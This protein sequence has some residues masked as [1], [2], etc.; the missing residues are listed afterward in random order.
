MDAKETRQF[1]QL[2]PRGEPPGRAVGRGEQ[3]WP[4]VAQGSSRSVCGRL[5]LQLWAPHR[6]PPRG[7]G[8]LTRWAEAPGA[9]LLE[10]LDLVLQLHLPSPGTELAQARGRAAAPARPLAVQLVHLQVLQLLPQVLDEL[11]GRGAGWREPGHGGAPGPRLGPTSCVASRSFW[12]SRRFCRSL[13]IMRLYRSI[14]SL[15][16]RLVSSSRSDMRCRSWG[17]RTGS[18]ASTVPGGAHCAPGRPR[19]LCQPPRQS[20]Q[21]PSLKKRPDPLG[22]GERS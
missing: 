16:R 4:Q 17:G 5:L 2:W 10:P 15:S 18:A 9:H 22:F 12:N 1:P 8:P 11:R 6:N 20:P 21:S 13:S 3:P 14:S 7:L 19:G